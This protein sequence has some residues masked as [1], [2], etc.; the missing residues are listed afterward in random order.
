MD[1]SPWR[2]WQRKPGVIIPL[3]LDRALTAKRE[4]CQVEN[5][6]FGTRELCRSIMEGA[7]EH[8]RSKM[9]NGESDHAGLLPM[10]WST[11]IGPEVMQRI[12]VP[13]V[14]GTVSGTVLTLVIIPAIFGTAKGSGLRASV[15]QIDAMTAMGSI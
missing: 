15:K 5:R 11:G 10:L 8:V 12:A 1:A 4:R 7:V 2:A 6:T 13:V 14:G 9:M 3:Y